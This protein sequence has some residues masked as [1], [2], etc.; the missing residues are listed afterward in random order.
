[1]M[2]PTDIIQRKINGDKIKEGKVMDD[3]NNN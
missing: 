2:H 3:G 1:M